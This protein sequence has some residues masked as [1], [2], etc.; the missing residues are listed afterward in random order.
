MTEK[1]SKKLRAYQVSGYSES[2]NSEGWKLFNVEDI[3]DIE[4]LN[5]QFNK[6]RP[7]YNRYEDRHIPDIIC[8]I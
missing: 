8:K 6:P 3:R 1:G 7:G 2:G 4:I 5:E